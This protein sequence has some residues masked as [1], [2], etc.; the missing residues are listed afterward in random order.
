MELTNILKPE[1]CRVRLISTKKEDVLHEISNLLC[2]NEAL[3]HL[4]PDIIYDYLSAREK[5]GSTGLGKGL[6][7]PHARIQGINDFIVG[8]AVSKQ[9]IA[10]D[11]IDKKK[12]QLFLY[13]IGPSE[14]TDDHLKILASISSIANNSKT[15]KELLN[16]KSDQTLYETLFKHLANINTQL[17]TKEK[18]KLILII[19]YFEEFLHDILEYL[20]GQGIDGATILE[21]SGMGRYISDVPLFAEFI[22]FLQERK[23]KS[24]TIIALIPADKEKHIVQGLEDI[25]GD[26]NSIQG[27]MFI[28]IDVGFYK[29]TMK[30]I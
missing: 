13:I 3:K 25:T 18:M 2:N 21:S 4:K 29:G 22:G 28:S 10:F 9:G 12:S 26:M 1:C 24:K 7:F 16:A 19:L 11:A 6:A 15:Q 8:I 23:D 20:L 30:M 14:A 27:A 17:N 5:E